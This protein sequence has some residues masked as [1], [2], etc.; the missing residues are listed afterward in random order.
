MVKIAPSLLA[1]DLLFLKDSLDAVKE[2]DMLHIDI[3]DGHFVPNLSMG[4]GFVKACKRGTELPLEVHLMVYKP[5]KF[6]SNFIEAGS[7]ILTVHVES[8]P[9]LNRVIDEIKGAGIKAGLALNPGTPLVLAEPVLDQIDFLLLM[10]VNPG[11]GGQEFIVGMLEKIRQ[12]K[13]LL[14]RQKK[15]IMLAVDGGVHLGNAHEIVEAG[16]DML[17]AGSAIYAGNGA[18]GVTDFKDALAKKREK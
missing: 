7:D 10:T 12:A 8:T 3:M 13:E 9:H 15:D 18:R 5:E 16:A 11:F 6:L 14:Q 2:A 1:A 4:P 17:I